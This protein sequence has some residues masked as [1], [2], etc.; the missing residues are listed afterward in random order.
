MVPSSF[1]WGV[2]V[3]AAMATLAPSRAAR[4]AIASPMPREAPVMN[5]VFPRSVAMGKN[6]SACKRRLGGID[7]VGAVDH[8]ALEA[9]GA[10]RQVLGE[11]ARG[12]DPTRGIRHGAD[13]DRGERLLRK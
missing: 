9:S 7:A 1:G 10:D 3:L 6:P 13:A 11:E 12:R 2:S 8:G 4:S 5:R